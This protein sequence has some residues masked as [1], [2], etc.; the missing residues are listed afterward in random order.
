MGWLKIQVKGFGSAI[1][2]TRDQEKIEQ[3]ITS[4]EGPEGWVGDV[5]AD[6]VR[7]QDCKAQS[8]AWCLFQAEL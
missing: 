6:Q 3:R 5:G 4:I 7:G 1:D 2:N 8:S